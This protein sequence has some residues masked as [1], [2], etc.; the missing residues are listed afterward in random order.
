MM[1]KC[2]FDNCNGNNLITDAFNGEIFCADCGTVIDEKLENHNEIPIHSLED[3]MTKSHVGPKQSLSMYDKGM[4]SVIG[5]DK[6][7]T[8]KPLNSFN[9]SRFNRLRILDSRSKTRKSSQRTLMKSLTF[10]NG[11]KEKLGI[12]ENTV[13][14][15]CSLF[16]RAQKHHLTKGRSSNHLMA[17]ALYV[18]CRQTMTPRS[19]DD[20]SD[21][22]NITRKYL[23]KAVRVLIDEF[24][25]N[26]PQYNTS[27]FLTKLSS[28]LGISEKTQR[29]ALSIL[30]DVEKCGSSAG[31]NPV[32]QAAASLYLASM[33]MGDNVNQRKFSEI[34][35]VST[36]TLR[37]RKNTIQKILN[38]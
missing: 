9:K 32:G 12:S 26:L 27:S 23:Q 37:N 14:I 16:R 17:A 7:S 24:G 25:L 36:V 35:G 5:K 31:K 22:G 4:Y 18:S 10:L 1:Q 19:L 28:D 20:I 13:E 11:L 6:D 38:L 8:G 30:S 33:L 2:Q 21:T 29:Y 34:S 3:F 15:T